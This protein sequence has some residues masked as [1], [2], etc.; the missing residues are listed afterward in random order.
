MFISQCLFPGK[1]WRKKSL[2]WKDS[3]PKSPGLQ[4]T[5]IVTCRSLW[6]LDQPARPSCIQ[7]LPIGFSRTEIFQSLS[8]NGPILLDGSSSTQL[9][10]SE[11]ES[12]YGRKVTR[13]TPLKKRQ[14]KECIKCLTVTRKHIRNC[15]VFLLS[16]V[17]RVKTRN[18][19][20]QT[21]LQ[22]AK[23]LFQKQVEPYRHVPLICWDRTLPGCLIFSFKIK[24]KKNN[25]LS[26]L[27]GDSPLDQLEY[28]L[29]FM[30]TIK[31]LFYLLELPKFR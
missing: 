22:L 12:S 18:S 10:S 2:I 17:I 4:S 16:K 15:Y 26:K 13:L 9:L 21:L 6:L 8:T 27:H 30:E 1:I 23:P 20:V 7:H 19:E 24:I 25:L 29:C 3:R 5:E 14:K 31:D 28:W 11:Q